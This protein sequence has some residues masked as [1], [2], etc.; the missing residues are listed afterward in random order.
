MTNPNSGQ[1]VDSTKPPSYSLVHVEHT[2]HSITPVVFNGNNYDEWSRSFH[3]ALMAKG[4]LGYIDGT[5]TKPSATSEKFETWQSTNA[6]VTM[7]IFNTIES[8]LRRQISL[9]PE[10]KQVWLDLKNRFSQANEARV[11]QLQTELLA[12]RQRP[13]E[14]L[15]AYYGRMTAIWDELLEQDPLPSCSCNPCTCDWVTLMAARR[16]K[17][18]VRDFLMGLDDRFSNTRTHIIGITPL[19]SLDLIYYRLLQ[20]EGVRNLSSN[21]SDKQPDAMAFAA[22]VSHGSRPSGGGGRSERQPSKYFCIACQK[23]SHSL[24]F[25][26]QVTGKYPEWWGDRPRPRI[27]LDPNA[28]DLTNAVFVPDPRSKGQTE[29]RGISSLSSGQK[30]LGTTS[31]VAGDHPPKALMASGKAAMHAAPSSSHSSL[32]SFDNID[33][34]SLTPQQLD[35]LSNL[36]Q[37]RKSESSTDR[38]NGPYLEDSDWCG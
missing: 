1:V 37:A 10:A 29:T 6:L 17:T 22:H 4:K 3:L 30:T 18:R 34:N 31:K 8:S 15:V 25:C 23:S 35:E 9:R 20:D 27:Y 11:Y 19:P 28:T 7:W 32:A 12:C 24:K 21:S 33:L 36:L 14:T 26:Y 16:E 2:G 38:L 5:I 13:T